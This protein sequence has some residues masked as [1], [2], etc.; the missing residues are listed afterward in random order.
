MTTRVKQVRHCGVCGEVGHNRR[1]CPTVAEVVEEV[2]ILIDTQR[3]NRYITPEPTVIL[4]NNEYIN[5]PRSVTQIRNEVDNTPSPIPP[6]TIPTLTIPTIPD[7]KLTVPEH[8]RLLERILLLNMKKIMEFD[9]K[10]FEYYIDNYVISGYKHYFNKTT[11]NKAEDILDFTEKIHEIM[12]ERHKLTETIF[13][14]VFKDDIL[15]IDLLYDDDSINNII[16]ECTVSFILSK[17]NKYISSQEYNLNFENKVN[18]L[19]ITE[20]PIE[21]STCLI[22]MDELGTTNKCILR[23]GHQYCSD[24]IF[25]HFQSAGGNNCPSCRSEYAVREYGW[26]PP[27]IL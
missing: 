27:S 15:N 11:Q 6:L 7:F 14:T 13:Y 4:E 18:Q 8:K 3:D 24:C 20:K 19:T 23:C 2:Q 25:R 17:I 10:S 26:V 1:T 5:S 12:D 22:C 9:L 21:T 16:N